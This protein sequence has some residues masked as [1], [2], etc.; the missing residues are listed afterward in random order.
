MSGSVVSSLIFFVG[1]VVV[2][3][4]FIGIANTSITSSGTLISASG[5]LLAKDLRSSVDI[6]HVNAS[7]GIAVYAVNTGAAFHDLTEV[8]ASIDGEWL[9]G[10]V[11][12]VRGD[13][14]SLWEPG[15]VV[16]VSNS[17]NNLALGWH[18]ARL[19]VQGRTWSPGFVFRR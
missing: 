8:R 2:V 11:V 17:S 6:V 1:S 7:S 14:D 12:V 3:S 4:A 10:S 19:L 15:E 5:D 18:E 16:R 13:G 9:E